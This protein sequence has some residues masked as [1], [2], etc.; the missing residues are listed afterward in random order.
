MIIMV[1]C[2]ILGGRTRASSPDVQNNNKNRIRPKW[3]RNEND[4]NFACN[5]KIPRPGKKRE[6]PGQT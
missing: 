3:W 2:R 1:I 6:K 5:Y 4:E